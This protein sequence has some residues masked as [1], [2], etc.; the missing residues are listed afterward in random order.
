MKNNLLQNR[1][2]SVTAAFLALCVSAGCGKT[3]EAFVVVS[4]HYKTEEVRRVA[5]ISFADYP[6]MSGSGE[7][8][9]GIFEKYLLG[10]GYRIVERRAVNEILKEQA[11]QASGVPDPA[12]LKKLGRLLGVQALVIGNIGEYKE[13]GEHTVMVQALMQHTTPVYGEVETT[14][15]NGDTTI[16]TTQKV[17]TSYN[18]AYTSKLVPRTEAIPARAALSAR[19][20]D[21]E[22][23]E[24]LWSAS[25]SSEGDYLSEAVENS[26]ALIM[27][28]VLQKLSG[29]S[30]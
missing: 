11:F 30:R 23:G 29:K 3:P 14:Q 19:L 5:L 9:A 22:T 24:V 13:P 25:A 15:K 16:K 18:H 6:G 1:P 8:A 10:S 27:E 26:S 12:T 21:A 17:I 28:A 4:P 7:A 2:L 20:V